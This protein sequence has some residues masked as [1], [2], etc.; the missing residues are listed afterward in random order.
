SAGRRE[1]DAF[2]APP[3]GG[4]GAPGGA[5]VLELEAVRA[6]PDTPG[7]ERR[8]ACGDGCR[9]GRARAVAPAGAEGPHRARAGREQGG[10]TEA[11]EQA[12]P[13]GEGQ[14]GAGPRLPGSLRQRRE[15]DAAAQAEGVLGRLLPAVATGDRCADV[16][17]PRL[18]G[19]PDVDHLAQP[20]EDGEVERGERGERRPAAEE[21]LEERAA[22]EGDG[23]ERERDRGVPER[24]ERPP[25]AGRGAGAKPQRPGCG[26][27]RG[28]REHG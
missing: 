10:E 15:R 4:A 5:V 7:D 12:E 13:A 18:L 1:Q 20:D 9:G 19:E 24:A 3:A 6:P 2:D 27:D 22:D 17:L 28:G 14:M 16:A 11:D 25:V 26:A 8:R 21:E 23:C